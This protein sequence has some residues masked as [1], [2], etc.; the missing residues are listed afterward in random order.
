MGRN[1]GGR[2]TEQ[3]GASDDLGDGK[4]GGI[5]G[6]CVFGSVDDF[7]EHIAARRRA[8]SGGGESPHTGERPGC[9]RASS[10]RD[11]SS[12]TAAARHTDRDTHPSLSDPRRSVAGAEPQSA[13]RELMQ[14]GMTFVS[15]RLGRVGH[16]TLRVVM[17]DE[18]ER[19]DRE[20]EQAAGRQCREADGRTAAG[21][22]LPRASPMRSVRSM[23]RCCL[24]AACSRRCSIRSAGGR[25]ASSSLRNPSISCSSVSISNLR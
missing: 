20:H 25:S 21:V 13:R 9:R 17:S 22:H 16:R 2:Q 5:D 8:E 7:V 18:N 19:A 11:E 24:S 10:A 12:Q 4:A 14:R 1:I 6:R 23:P 15:R 3:R